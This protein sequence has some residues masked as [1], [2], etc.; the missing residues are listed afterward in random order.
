MT[1]TQLIFLATN[2]AGT[3]HVFEGAAMTAAQVM[4]QVH[5][6]CA[7]PVFADEPAA[8]AA[9]ATW[10]VAVV[11]MRGPAGAEAVSVGLPVATGAQGS[12]GDVA[13]RCGSCGGAAG[14]ATAAASQALTAAG[15]QVVYARHLT[16]RLPRIAAPR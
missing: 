6:L 1:K 12:G 11:A 14:P 3:G 10:P 4:A 13:A 5:A 16:W 2:A 7:I 15:W 8:V 9:G